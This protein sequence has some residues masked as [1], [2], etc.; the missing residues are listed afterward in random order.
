MKIIRLI[1]TYPRAA[2]LCAWCI[3]AVIAG[4][5]W[6]H[7]LVSKVPAVTA[8][9]ASDPVSA[10]PQGQPTKGTPD[11][12]TILPG[13]T[14]IDAYGGWTRVSPPKSDAVFAYKDKIAGTPVI[15]SQQPLPKEFSDQPE[16]QV[17]LFAERYL[18]VDQVKSGDVTVYIGTSG[19]GPQSAIFTK[20][21][22]LILIKAS[23]KLTNEQWSDYVA[24]L[25]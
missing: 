10:P 4:I 9:A 15:V 21:R 8:T 25:N 17:E 12:D 1:T 6:S 18:A 19:K 13:N 24:S 11:F 22:L 20:N 16:Q 5:A 23:A 3:I 2:N 7:T 14:K